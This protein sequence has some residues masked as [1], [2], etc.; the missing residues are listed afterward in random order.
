MKEHEKKAMNQACNNECDS[1]YILSDMPNLCMNWI[2]NFVN[3]IRDNVQ[4]I[5]FDTWL[6]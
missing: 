3:Q 6:V 1:V 5:M 4:L 2:Q